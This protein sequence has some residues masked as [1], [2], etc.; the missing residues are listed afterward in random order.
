MSDH[1]TPL[2]ASALRAPA[3]GRLKAHAPVA[4]V[5][6][7]VGAL[8]LVPLGYLVWRT[9]FDD[10]TL[11]L[12]FM[13]E[14]YA[15][16]GLAGMAASSL[17]FAA[18]ATAVAL[19]TG[20]P[21]A[22][23]L[24]RTDLPLRRTFLVV[25][26]LP[27]VVPGV[28]YTIAW[29]FLASPNAGLINTFVGAHVVDVFGLG[30]MIVV[31]GLH[32][33][34]LVVILTAAALRSLDT[35]LEET[36]L[37]SGASLGT[38][39]RR[40]TL[41]LLRPALLA[42]ALLSLIRALESF[43]VPALIGIPGGTWVFTSRVY[44]ALQTFPDG[45]A[46]A[47]A[48][49]LPLIALT[50]CGAAVLAALTRRR[51][52]Y[53]IVTGRGAGRRPLP[54]GRWRAPAA[55]AVGAY[56]ALS[57]ALPVLALVWISTQ[58]YLD[59]PSR[60]SFARA[61]LAGYSDVL[62]SERTLH[63]FWNSAVL[64]TG[65]ATVT[66]MLGAVI[67]WLAVRSRLRGRRLADA[68]AFLP[69]ALPGVVLG[70]ALLAFWLRIPWSVYGTLWIL[71]IAYV[72]AHLPYGVRTATVAIGQLGRELEEAAQVSGASWL[73][74]FR[75]VILPLAGPGLLA[76]W[77]TVVVFTMRE[78]SASIVLYTPGNDVLAVR[79][80]QEYENGDFRAVAALGII[81]TAVS[82]VLV[83][84]AALL[85]RQLAGQVRRARG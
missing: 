57:V 18:G 70:A 24:V 42:A 60:E 67:G 30:G 32:L 58:P 27:L 73:Q 23:L 29:I 47:G 6:V 77:I 5:L 1:A 22:W 25:A 75:R 2:R 44:A 51:R 20:V 78:L 36:A 34:P 71:L 13:R 76:G 39:L 52:A 80:W 10:G 11:T 28:L 74:A 85:A 79:I 15:A 68:G 83:G 50:C 62:S 19:L 55:A 61:S 46:L 38:L 49:A 14:A 59:V 48:Y 3:L 31:E 4:A 41:P 81:V 12:R 26:L 16:D 37:C 35:S 84:A 9:F 17:V 8:V 33:T 66:L 53:E 21:L 54:L 82:V 65:A 69:L 56:L 7:V 43:E 45:I 40:I 64:G 72:T 63:A